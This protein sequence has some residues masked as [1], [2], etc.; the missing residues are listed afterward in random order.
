[1]DKV[2]NLTDILKP[3][4]KNKG[5]FRTKVI[6]GYDPYLDKNG[7]TRFGEVVFER[8]N[9]IVLSG[10][11]FALEK[12]FGQYVGDSN[13]V[14]YLDNFIKKSDETIEGIDGITTTPN[15]EYPEDGSIVCLFGA[16]TGGASESGETVFSVNYYDRDIN[17]MVPFAQT[18]RNLLVENNN[19][20]WF[21]KSVN[22]NGSDKYRYY[23][24]EFENAPEIKVLYKSTAE[25]EDGVRVTGIPSIYTGV[26]NNNS[27]ETFIE[28]TLKIMNN[29][30]RDYFAS[31]STD[32]SPY[33]NT[34]GLYTGV[35]K[36]L[37]DG[38]VDYRHVRLFSKLNFN[39]EYLNPGK[40]MT[41]KYR[42]YTN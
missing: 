20:Y 23:L 14:D 11:M 3:D 30:F 24:K 38:T 10:S 9:M 28:L 22:I 12:L 41:I 42:I 18:N 27:I 4:D 37:N 6:G 26:A 16:G 39:N 32:T 15:A 21:R 8:S 2:I 13:S 17:G 34:I 33:I 25:G 1:M 36:V 5:M 40:D 7:I 31:L 35:K 19:K 29:D